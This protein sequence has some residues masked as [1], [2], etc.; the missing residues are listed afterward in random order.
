MKPIIIMEPMMIMDFRTVRGRMIPINQAIICQSTQNRVKT[1]ARHN[2]MKT[3]A[4][5]KFTKRC[6]LGYFFDIAFKAGIFTM[7]PFGRV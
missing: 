7:S 5:R 2:A 1:A 6:P 3:R 4:S